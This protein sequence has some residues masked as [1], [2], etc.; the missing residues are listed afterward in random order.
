MSIAWCSDICEVRSNKKF[1]LFGYTHLHPLNTNLCYPEK[2]ITQTSIL[3]ATFAYELLPT[4]HS[5]DPT[6]APCLNKASVTLFGGT[7]YE[8]QYPIR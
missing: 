5:T 8:E 6:G 2:N 1:S 3:S 7:G 4:S